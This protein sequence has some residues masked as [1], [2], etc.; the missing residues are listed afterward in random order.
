[1]DWYIGDSV[2][3]QCGSMHTGDLY[4]KRDKLC[5]P[6]ISKDHGGRSQLPANTITHQHCIVSRGA[7]NLK[8]ERVS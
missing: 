6:I 8:S 2:E 5:N 7:C 1:M 4:P 3:V